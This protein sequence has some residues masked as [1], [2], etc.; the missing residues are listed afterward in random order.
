LIFEAVDWQQQRAQNIGYMQNQM[1]HWTRHP[2]RSVVAL[3][4]GG[5]QLQVGW[6]AITSHDRPGGARLSPD[7]RERATKA[8]RDFAE[9]LELHEIFCALFEAEDSLG[10][11]PYD[12]ASKDPL[13]IL[14][15]TRALTGLDAR[16]VFK[17]GDRF[18]PKDDSSESEELAISGT[19]EENRNHLE[20][21]LLRVSSGAISSWDAKKVDEV[22]EVLGR[23][24]LAHRCKLAVDWLRSF[25]FR[26]GAAQAVQI[27][28][29][30]QAY[31]QGRLSV[32]EVA[33]VIGVSAEEALFL[34]ERHG[35]F[36]PYDTARLSIPDRKEKL[37]Q[38][39]ADRIARGNAPVLD[40]NLVA[41]DV[42]SSHRIEDLDAR[43]WIPK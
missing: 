41:R 23:Q 36:R 15:L 14:D 40:R 12:F 16:E 27:K 7:Y 28:A 32:R 13:Q 19:A 11:D 34:L 6:L 9:I 5:K 21:N 10:F 30:G 42:I 2:K 33:S 24:A 31:A 37:T 17:N 8:L 38:I 22:A 43:P 20:A 1:L 29:A 35:Y 25:V 3:A 4:E 26:R 39:R 18:F